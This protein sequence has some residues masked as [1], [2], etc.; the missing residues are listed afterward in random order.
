[1]SEQQNVDKARTVAVLRDHLWSDTP[2]HTC[3]CG[4]QAE[5]AWMVDLTQPNR[6]EQWL[7]H[8]AAEVAAAS[9]LSSGSQ[10]ASDGED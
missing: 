9:S 4:W 8:V 3:G 1:M 2:A 7:D 10:E 6:V 5:P